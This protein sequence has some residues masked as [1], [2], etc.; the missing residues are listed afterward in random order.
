MIKII[1]SRSI[2][3]LLVQFSALVKQSGLQI[4]ISPFQFR[5]TP[6]HTPPLDFFF[7]VQYT[8]NEVDEEKTETRIA[9]QDDMED[10]ERGFPSS[11]IVLTGPATHLAIHPST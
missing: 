10:E 11:V 6:R 9:S 2:Q 5:R 3:L 8:K 1:V 7:Q 4:T